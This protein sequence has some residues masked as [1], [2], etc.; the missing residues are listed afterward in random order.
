MPQNNSRTPCSLASAVSSTYQRFDVD[1]D[2]LCSANG[3]SY[4]ANFRIKFQQYDNYGIA[5]DGFAFDDITVEVAQPPAITT[6]PSDVIVTEPDAATF[7]VVATGVMPMS[8]QWRMDSADIVGAT[9]STYTTPPTTLAD[10]GSIFTSQI[11]APKG[12]PIR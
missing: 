2:T 7:A 3:I 10:E 6:H 4:N 1:L 5:T 11:P 8:Y 9:A 12:A